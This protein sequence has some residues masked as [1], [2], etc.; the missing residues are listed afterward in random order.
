MSKISIA[1]GM[2][3]PA[4]ALAFVMGLGT[5]ARSAAKERAEPQLAHMVFFTLKERAPEAR[6]KLAASCRKYLAG[7]E[8]VV[9]FS[10]GTAADDS[11]EP[12]VS[13]HD[14]DVA[15]HTVFTSRDAKNAYLKHPDHVEFVAEN[16][17]SFAKVRV[18][19]SY[20][21]KP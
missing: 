18:F 21:T 6:E 4:L 20:L 5:S 15:L 12:G 11:D 19:D 3:V 7:I 9:T 17:A 1:A 13:V 2:T 10:V 8:G 14:F 16:R